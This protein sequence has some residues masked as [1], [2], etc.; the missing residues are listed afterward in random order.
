MGVKETN[1][2]HA[3]MLR[4]SPQGYS[5]WKNVRGVFRWL[6]SENK[7]TVGIGPDGASDLIGFKSVIVTP[8]M[9]GKRVAIFTAIESKTDEG[10]LEKDQ[11]DFLK[12]VE[13]Y[14][15]IAAVARGDNLIF[16]LDAV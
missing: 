6:K 15:G 9:V 11:L 4:L 8:D 7:I 3:W 5:L 10:R 1:V 13:G 2:S 12:A 16:D 14:G